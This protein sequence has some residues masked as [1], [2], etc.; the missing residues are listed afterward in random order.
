MADFNP[1]EDWIAVPDWLENGGLNVTLYQGTVYLT[2]DT[3]EGWWG[4]AFA[5]VDNAA[6]LWARINYFPEAAP[7]ADGWLL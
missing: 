6:A 3:G 4:V 7:A 1:D 2:R 5:G